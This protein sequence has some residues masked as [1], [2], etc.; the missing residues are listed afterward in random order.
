MDAIIARIEFAFADVPRPPDGELLHPE[1]SDDGDLASLYGVEEWRKLSD[2]AIEYEYSALAFLSPAGF[3][4]FLPAYMRW[5][6]RHGD[7]KP[8]AAVI[9]STFQALTPQQG[10]LAAFSL[11]KFSLL[12]AEQSS[13]IAAFLERFSEHPDA[14]EARA[15]WRM[16]AGYLPAAAPADGEQQA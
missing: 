1:C 14:Q 4:H 8:G 10:A 13:C 3:R 6:C 15:Y 7:E 9:G 11:S 12:G 16:R 2:E 5:I